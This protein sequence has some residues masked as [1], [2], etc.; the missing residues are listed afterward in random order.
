MAGP[1]VIVVHRLLKNTIADTVGYRHYLFMSDA[2]A[3]RLGLIDAGVAHRERY[4]DIG[5]IG[6]RVFKL[7]DN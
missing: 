1:A 5:E 6:G 2:A 7:G 4:S 3:H